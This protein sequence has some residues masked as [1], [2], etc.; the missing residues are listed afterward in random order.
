MQFERAGALSWLYWTKLVN[1]LVLLYTGVVGIID[2]P[3]LVYDW[4]YSDI[5]TLCC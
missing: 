3:T 1:T 2:V 5:V 4:E